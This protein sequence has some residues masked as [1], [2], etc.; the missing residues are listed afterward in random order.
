MSVWYMMRVVYDPFFHQRSHKAVD[1][2]LLSEPLGRAFA[3]GMI[4]IPIRTTQSIALLRGGVAGETD[5]EGS[6]DD[7]TFHFHLVFFL[8]CYATVI[9]ACAVAIKA[10]TVGA[11]SASRCGRQRAANRCR[12]M[13]DV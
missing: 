13:T 11:I 8:V 9:R 4:G 10:I 6:G 1:T 7:K 2:H 12:S 5:C 3:I